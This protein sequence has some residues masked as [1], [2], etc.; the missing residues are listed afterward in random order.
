MASPS[1]SYVSPSLPFICAQQSLIRIPLP[2][3]SC[4]QESRCDS[5]RQQ[6][7]DVP[8]VAAN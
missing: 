6:E 7:A 4:V 2:A 1:S 8:A 3:G 5:V